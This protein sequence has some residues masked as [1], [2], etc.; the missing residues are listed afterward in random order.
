MIAHDAKRTASK[1]GAE[2]EKGEGKCADLCQRPAFRESVMLSEN[3]RHYYS[4]IY[5]SANILSVNRFADFPYEKPR[6][7]D[8]YGGV[9]IHAIELHLRVFWGALGYN[10][11]SFSG[12]IMNII[13]IYYYS[14][15][16][17]IVIQSVIFS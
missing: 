11:I 9:I 5:Y 3:L 4:A 15:N 2:S 10:T 17:L 8:G 12:R 16:I 13:S 7:T 1:A 6:K 14:A